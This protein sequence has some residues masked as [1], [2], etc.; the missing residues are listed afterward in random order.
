VLTHGA[1]QQLS[2][3]V[4]DQVR[5]AEKPQEVGRETGVETPTIARIMPSLLLRR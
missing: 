1:Q 2:P 5:Q 3:G 4:V